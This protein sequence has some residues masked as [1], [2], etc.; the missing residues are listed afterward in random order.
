MRPTTSPASSARADCVHRLTIV[1]VKCSVPRA[2]LRRR[3]AFTPPVALHDLRIVSIQLAQLVVRLK[4][5][6][7]D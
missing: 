6:K 4:S 1:P 3:R 2:G 7:G 5:A